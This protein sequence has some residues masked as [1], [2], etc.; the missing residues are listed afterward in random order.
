M[1]QTSLY[2]SFIVC[3]PHPAIPNILSPQSLWKPCYESC[4]TNKRDPRLSV[5]VVEGNDQSAEAAHLAARVGRT[6][7]II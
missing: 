7:S 2:M 1:R 3:L 4:T 5:T 6:S